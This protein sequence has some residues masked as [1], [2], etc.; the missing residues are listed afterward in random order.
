MLLEFQDDP[1]CDYLDRQ[2]MLG[3]SL[4]V[5]PVFNEDGKVKYYLPEGCWTIFLSGEVI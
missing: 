2:F 5:A 4:M 3:D 1:G